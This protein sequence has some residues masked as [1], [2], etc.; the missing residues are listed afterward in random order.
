MSKDF[1]LEDKKNI[2]MY[3]VLLRYFDGRIENINDKILKA[4]KKGKDKDGTVIEHIDKKVL[5][6]LRKILTLKKG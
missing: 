3:L 5:K 4:L 1:R 2:D 6:L